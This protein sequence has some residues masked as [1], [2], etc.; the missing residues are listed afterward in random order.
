MLNLCP[1]GGRSLRCQPA[2][3]VVAWAN[4]TVDSTAVAS[5]V[6]LA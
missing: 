6:D 4:V 3:N 1:A 5:V 2:M